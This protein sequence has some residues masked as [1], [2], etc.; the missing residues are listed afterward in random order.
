MPLET[1]SINYIYTCGKDRLSPFHNKFLVLFSNP[2]TQPPV[3]ILLP[4]LSPCFIC[5]KVWNCFPQTN[6]HAVYEGGINW[7]LGCGNLHLRYN[8]CLENKSKQEAAGVPRKLPTFHIIMDWVQSLIKAA[9]GMP[10]SV[11]C[12]CMAFSP[13]APSPDIPHRSGVEGGVGGGN[14]NNKC[15]LRLEGWD[16]SFNL[17][18]FV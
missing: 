1:V 16:A 7:G 5:N 13:V 3:L 4:Q 8:F 9:Q 17:F 14:W 12:D 18:W 15:A 6:L 10:T 11:T 2:S